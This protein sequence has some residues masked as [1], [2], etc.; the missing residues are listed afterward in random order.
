MIVSEEVIVQ[1]EAKPNLLQRTVI[2]VRNRLFTID[3]R[4]QLSVDEKVDR[5]RESLLR[6]V[7]F[8]KND[9]LQKERVYET[10]MNHA[11]MDEGPQEEMIESAYRSLNLSIMIYEHLREKVKLM[12]IHSDWRYTDSIQVLYQHNEN[13][14]G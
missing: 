12:Y 11:I 7:E 14:V 10:L 1:K 2:G 4:N 13:K 9:Y 3:Q 6:Q 5:Y 8:A